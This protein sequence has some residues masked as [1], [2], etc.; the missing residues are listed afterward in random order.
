[1]ELEITQN[2]IGSSTTANGSLLTK[3]HPI[4]NSNSR[5]PRKCSKQT[6]AT[7]I[8]FIYIPN[9]LVHCWGYRRYVTEKAGTSNDS[10][11][12]FTT[13]KIE[14]NFS[15]YSSWHQR[16]KLIPQLFPTPEQLQPVLEEG[17]FH[18]NFF[19]NG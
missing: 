12:Q 1:V 5:S 6:N 3:Q 15:N 11:F 17:K 16:S 13:K 14:E 18:G 4:G 8:N 19:C 2:R 9:H 10:E 7:V